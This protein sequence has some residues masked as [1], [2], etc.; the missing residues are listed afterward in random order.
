VKLCAKIGLSSRNGRLLSGKRLIQESQAALKKAA[1]GG[2]TGIVGF[3][4]DPQKY[5]EFL[6]KKSK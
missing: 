2:E 5:R 3:R 1:S 4:S 6:A